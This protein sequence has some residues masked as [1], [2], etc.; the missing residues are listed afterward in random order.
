VETIREKHTCAHRVDELLAICPEIGL[1]APAKQAAK[2]PIGRN[3]QSA[4]ART[5]RHA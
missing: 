4:P 1:D 2:E 5:E 3:E